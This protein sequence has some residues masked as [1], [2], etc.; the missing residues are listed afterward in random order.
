MFKKVSLYSKY[1]KDN[2]S[3][4]ERNLL[5]MFKI[6]N[7]SINFDCKTFLDYGCGKGNLSEL[8][9]I[10]KNC[11]VYKYD[12]A[13]PEFSELKKNIKVDLI[14]NCD[15][16]EHIPEDEIDETLKKMSNISSKVFFNIYLKEAKTFLPNGENALS[17]LLIGG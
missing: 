13:I 1:Y 10:K 17:N 15:V 11:I 5:P 2:F 6:I 12:P 14:A 4:Y 7:A 3:N 8:F 16:M 9:K